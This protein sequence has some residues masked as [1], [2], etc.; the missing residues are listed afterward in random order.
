[1]TF[2]FVTSS[3]MGPVLNKR[4][5]SKY[6]LHCQHALLSEIHVLVKYCEY[7]QA[8]KTK[9]KQHLLTALQLKTL[10]GNSTKDIKPY[11]SSFQS[12]VDQNACKYYKKKNGGDYWTTD[13]PK[14]KRIQVSMTPQRDLHLSAPK[15]S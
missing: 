12:P 8:S 2:T 14:R 6:C 9:S 13:K 15:Y 5:Y 1:M 10:E 4:T 3:V 7:A 11:S